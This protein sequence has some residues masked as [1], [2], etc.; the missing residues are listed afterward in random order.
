MKKDFSTVPSM[1]IA[2]STFNRSFGH[3]TTFNASLLIPFFCDELLP[4]DSVRLGA[5]CFVRQATPIFPIM[6]NL[7]VDTHF[8]FVPNR[9]VWDNWQKFM[10]EQEKPGDSTDFTIPTRATNTYNSNTIFDYF[11]LPVGVA[12]SHNVLPLRGYNLIY[13]EWFRDENL[14]DSVVVNTADGPET[15]NNY[16]LLRRGKRH[17]YFT[18][19]LPWPQKGPGVDLPLGASAPV[20]SNAADL[21]D[22]T[23]QRGIGTGNYDKLLADTTHVR[24]GNQSGTQTEALFADLSNA[25]ASTIND[26][27]T[28]FQIQRLQERDA[29]GGTRYR[30]IVMSHFRTDT[31]D[32]RVN[33]PEYLGGGSSPISTH[34]VPQTSQTTTGETA[35][36]QGRLAAF[37]RA[38]FT[39]G[40]TY[41]AKEH[42]YIIGLISVRADLTYQRGLERFWSRSTKYDFFWPTL[43][44]LGEQEVKNKEI[45]LAGDASDEQTFGYQER[46]AEYRYKP[47]MIT[48]LFRSKPAGGATSLDPWH[49]SQDFAD[50]RPTLG[51]T[52]IEENVPMARINAVNTEPD[53]LADIYFD[54]KCARPVPV[55]GVPGYIDHF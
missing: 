53:F 2:R 48:G 16:E 8:F 9:L 44:H 38:S 27:R 51:K 28:A 3:K 12:Y 20:T 5:N 54:Y 34:E 23:V 40:F 6:D 46:Y 50:V 39:H 18:S 7:Y 45:Y 41:S 52:F 10:G 43:A 31:G 14:I 22:I 1:K 29:R 35:S 19:C 55:H 30:E 33:R 13:N 15:G 37:A 25:T 26:L 4:A 36:P 47:S 24:Q 11:G 21:A 49:L 42:G 17:D 32:A